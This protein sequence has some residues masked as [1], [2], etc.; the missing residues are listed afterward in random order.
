MTEQTPPLVG[1]PIVELYL[2][3]GRRFFVPGT[4]ITVAA[5]IEQNGPGLMWMD[6]ITGEA[7]WGQRECDLPVKELRTQ[8]TNWPTER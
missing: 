4:T 5:Q 6:E 3:S 7:D 1:D 8:L 2:T